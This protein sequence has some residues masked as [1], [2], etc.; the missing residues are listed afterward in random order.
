MATT[1]STGALVHDL[2]RLIPH[3]DSPRGEV[4]QWAVSLLDWCWPEAERA[5]AE[6]LKRLSDS[7]A[8]VVDTALESFNLPAL[9]S[10][11]DENFT[12]M[13]GRSGIWMTGNHSLIGVA[14]AA[15][16]GCSTRPEL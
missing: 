10:L 15:L 6:A 4:R 5:V 9:T 1:L 14:F 2:D 8:S 3:L 12:S 11:R 13:V 7:D 16:R